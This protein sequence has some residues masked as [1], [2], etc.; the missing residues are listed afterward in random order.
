MINCPYGLIN[1]VQALDEK[2]DWVCNDFNAEKKRLFK[3]Q[4]RTED[5][6]QIWQGGPKLRMQHT[7]YVINGVEENLPF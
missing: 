3:K 7:S 5:L 4:K 1:T 6:L 2:I